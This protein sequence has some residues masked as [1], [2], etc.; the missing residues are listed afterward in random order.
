M[1]GYYLE[2]YLT[3]NNKLSTRGVIFVPSIFA[4]LFAMAG[5]LIQ[6]STFVWPIHE[7]FESMAV[8]VGFDPWFW[9][10]LIFDALDTLLSLFTVITFFTVALNWY[11]AEKDSEYFI[12]ISMLI[13]SLLMLGWNFA[14]LI[15]LST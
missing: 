1:A 7:Y 12:I 6:L 3:A 4:G 15:T 14:E 13:S 2:Q 8:A 5:D 9:W 11:K 10:M